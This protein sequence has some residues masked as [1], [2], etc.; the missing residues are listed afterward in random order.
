MITPKLERA[1][2]V[3]VPL[4]G[5][6]IA[7]R[8]DSSCMWYRVPAKVLEVS[9][10]APAPAENRVWTAASSTVRTGDFKRLPRRGG[11]LGG[12]R[13]GPWL[14]RAFRDCASGNY[15]ADLR[16]LKG[17]VSRLKL[18]DCT[19]LKNVCRSRQTTPDHPRCPPLA[20]ASGAR[21][22]SGLANASRAEI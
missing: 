21:E 20:S 19:P 3:E 9:S 15:G 16:C 1:G 4:A 5:R 13:L 12:F 10:C 8:P 17:C 2:Q 7:N 22:R 11:W 14:G 6:Q 18:V